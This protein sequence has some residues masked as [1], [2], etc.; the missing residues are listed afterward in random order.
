MQNVSTLSKKFKTPKWKQK[1][2]E[3]ASANRQHRA[4]LESEKANASTSAK[5]FE[6]Q[7]KID[8]ISFGYLGV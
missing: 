3:K 6:I 5:K 4:N 8:K 1:K 7:Q 2:R